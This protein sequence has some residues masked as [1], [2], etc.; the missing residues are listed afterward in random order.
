AGTGSFLDQ[1]VSRLKIQDIDSF[2]EI[3]FSNK[4]TIPPIASRCAVFAKTDLI[5]AQQEGYSLPQ[6]CDSLCEGLV[7]NLSDTLFG[8]ETIKKP[9]IFTGG[10]SKN[11]AVIKHLAAILGDMPIVKEHSHLYGAIGATLIYLNERKLSPLNLDTPESFIT[12]NKT[13]LEYGYRAL[14]LKYSV[15]PDFES[16]E[17][18][19][20]TPYE[21]VTDAVEVDIYEPL[22]SLNAV[23]MGIDIGSTSTKAVLINENCNVLAGFYTMTAGQPLKAV[24]LIFKAIDKISI[25]KDIIFKFKGV[26]TTGA[27]RKFIGKIIG[28]D[29]IIDEITSHARAAFKLDPDV[30]T[31][32]EI[33]GQDSKFTTLKNGMVTFCAMNN[34]CAAGTGSFI[35]EQALKLG[36]ALSDYSKRAMHKLSPV[37][38]NRCTVFMERDINHFLSLGYGTDEILASVLHSVRDNYFSKVSLEANIGN[39]IFFQGATARNKALVAAFENKL[40]KPILVSKFCHLT[41]ALG[42]ALILVESNI[43]KS[44]FRGISI[45]K[46]EIPVESDVCKFCHNNCKIKKVLIQNEVVTFGYLCG[47]DDDHKKRLDNK[48]FD[49]VKEYKRI[50]KANNHPQKY[51]RDI[52][53]GIPHGLYLSDEFVLWEHFFN[54]L[55]IKTVSSEGVKD[56]L[57]M[58]KKTAKAEFC[59]PI[60][61]FFGQVKYL[62]EKVDYLFLP[63]YFESREKEKDAFRH[64]CYYTQF[65]VSLV[66]SSKGININKKS[67]MPVIYPGDFLTKVELFRSL[68]PVTGVDYW[69]IMF[70]YDNALEF[71]KE[72]KTKM[73]S[74]YQREFEHGDDINV[75]LLGRPYV[76]LDNAMNKGIPGIFSHLNTKTYYHD[77]LSFNK[78]EVKEIEPLLKAFH[79]NYTAK[80]LAAALIIAKTR[81]LYPVYI[82]SFKCSPDSFALEYFKSIM[83]MYEKPYIILD[84]DEHGSNV[85]YETRIEASIRA[86]KNHFKE[87]KKTGVFKNYLSLNPETELAISGKTLLFPSWD[88]ITVKLVE[89][90]LIKEGIDARMVPVTGH[91]IKLGLKS[92]KGQCLPVSIIYQSF[93]DYIKNNHLNPLN[94]TVWMLNSNLACNIRL[95]PYLIKSMFRTYGKG[96]EHISVYTGSI[97]LSDI[98][99]KTS[100]ETYF[101]YMFGGMLRKMG[102]KIRPYEKEKGQ[103]DEIIRQSQAIFYDAFL[104]KNTLEKAVVE[105]VNKFQ[106]V[107]IEKTDRPKVAIF[108][109]IYV[110]DNDIM[111]Q[112]I[113]KCI[114]D[115]GGE[116]ITISLSDFAKMVTNSYVK[117]YLYQWRFKAAIT[118]KGIMMMAG[119]IES[120]YYKYFNEILQEREV[121][122]TVDFKYIMENF[123]VMPE[124]DGESIDNLIAIFSLLELHPDISLFVQLSPAFCCAGLI[125]ESMSSSIESITGVPLVSLTYDGT[126]KDQNSK[127]IPYIKYPK[128]KPSII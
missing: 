45:H 21:N 65:A 110:R 28:A 3:A 36:C 83:E 99:L 60:M 101:A 20:Y 116:V 126:G 103:T 124:H 14:E 18:F 7:K 41:G 88:N 31:I 89:A 127:I 42:C 51:K 1:Q 38:S 29:Q 74:I 119:S 37:S 82:S 109:D 96:M 53:I 6:I 22:A 43:Q 115:A 11:K 98:S 90:L 97:T 23:Y 12:E 120:I 44:K 114:E 26:A 86:F 106:T 121:K 27:G 105:V 61:D 13:K 93:L 24:Q 9:V 128:N 112:N 80:I 67:I 32:I 76:L 79:W 125:T 19:K 81:G 4:D 92:N 47:R 94:T 25:Q 104:G 78:E 117:R 108:G 52:T 73:N 95:Y 72:C 16:L 122:N 91:S 84:L 71:Y 87:Q 77:M 62:S 111:N 58:G 34:V 75:M 64:Y 57:K 50:F 123:H 48:R 85:G 66:S 56:S 70:A 35:E 55:G 54:T 46:E 8:A 107:K 118:G 113:I 5:H 10:V 49:L 30:D 2:C 102:C 69:S 59:T 39:K 100:I 68:R 33:G 15:Y 17:K 63:V 40:N